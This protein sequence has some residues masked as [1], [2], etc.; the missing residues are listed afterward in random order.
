MRDEVLRLDKSIG[1]VGLAGHL[2]NLIATMY[3]PGLVALS[4]EE[5]TEAYT[6]QAIQRMGAIRGGRKVGRLEGWN[7]WWAD[8]RT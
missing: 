8:S 4:T 2:G 6:I 1:Y 3:K 7:T 5:E